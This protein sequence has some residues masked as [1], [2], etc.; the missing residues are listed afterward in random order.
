MD[1]YE[2]KICSLKKDMDMLVDDM[3]PFTENEYV[4][5]YTGFPAFDVLKTVFEFI[6]PPVST[7]TKLANYV[8]SFH[9]DTNEIEARQSPKAYRFNIC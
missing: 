7:I 9:I 2:R 6:V 4:K 1:Y 3:H 5:L 8:P